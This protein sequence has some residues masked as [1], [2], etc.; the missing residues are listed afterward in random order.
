MKKQKQT[1]EELSIAADSQPDLLCVVYATGKNNGFIGKQLA[2]PIS[3]S[4]V[5]AILFIAI[6]GGKNEFEDQKD[7]ADLVSK[8]RC[9]IGSLHDAAFLAEFKESKAKW[10]YVADEYT[11][12]NFNQVLSSFQQNKKNF[13][14]SGVCIGEFNKTSGKL[15]NP[16]SLRLKRLGFNFLG[17]LLL[18][19]P[20]KDFTHQYLFFDKN[21]VE[22]YFSKNYKNSLSL[23]CK[24]VYENEPIQTYTLTSKDNVQIFSKLGNVIETAFTSRF[25]WFIR[26][27]FQQQRQAK[28]GGNHPYFRLTFLLVVLLA[29]ILLPTLSFDYGITWDA[30]RHNIYG[31][32]ML[33][34]FES[35]GEDKTALSETSSMNEFRYYGEHF[36]VISAWFN[37]NIQAWG[38]FETR[39]FLNALYSFLA[40]L[41]AA[42]ATKEVGSWRSGLFA[43]VFILFS[44]VFFGHGMNNPTDIPFAAGCMMALYYLIKVLKHLPSPKFTYLL[45][46]GAGI[47]MAIG[48]RIGGVVFYAYTGLF[49]GISWL[50]ILKKNGFAKAST[51]FLAYFTSGVT[52]VVIAHLVGISL[53]P[54]G[55]E[56][57]LTNW[58]VALKKSTSA[59]FFTFN[60]ELFEGKRMYMANVPWYYLPKFIIINSPLYIIIGFV[61]LLGSAFVWKRRFNANAIFILMVLFVLLFPIVYAEAQGM[62]Y[63]NGWRH[64]LF[65][66]PPLIILTALGWESLFMISK[67]KIVQVSVTIVLLG[68]IAL[69]ATWMV[70]NHPNEVVYYNE[71]IGGTKGAYGNYELDYYSNSCREAAEWIAHKHPKGKLLVAINNEPLTA[72]YY[73]HKINPDI[74]FQ[75][76]REYEEGKPFW[77]YAIYTSRTYSK[78]ELLNGG[79]PFK[80]TVYEVKADGVPLCVV[81]K[82]NKFDMPLGYKALEQGRLDSAIYYFTSACNDNPMDEEAFRM[83]GMALY[84]A[85][86]VDEA[87]EATNQSIKIF[88]ENYAAYSNLGLFYANGKK[89][90]EKALALLNQSLSYKINYTDAYYYA[91]SIEL[92]RGNNNEAITYLENAISRG[93]N[94]VP[95]MY[96]NL[97]LAYYNVGG[98]GKAEE[99]LT[100]CVTLDAKNAMAYRLLVEV[101]TKQGKKQEA[102]YCMQKYQE[103]GGK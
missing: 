30:K 8:G 21:I 60:H 46:C 69:P 86:R 59:E 10:A 7:I 37:K 40:M 94:G 88:P 81:V 100:Y 2:L 57:P 90:V 13:A 41:F 78:N 76:V 23:L 1:I 99:N 62:Y 12:T 93:G 82:R 92:N 5:N 96:Y 4:K 31:Y 35:D 103:L 83:K 38:E 33:K 67:N 53:W 22:N 27:A 64:Y 75:W 18:P 72:A 77:D 51:T 24:A 14:S 68:F 52:I 91:A 49:M 43:F 102:Q 47:G 9:K 84:S 63:Y 11:T 80:G 19:L 66:Y 74:Q 20:L 87:I 89:D 61:L 17:Q 101:F 36:N 6:E 56:E 98:Y 73:A 71:L 3:K 45:W 48:S 42:L 54:F 32:D 39:H 15:N 95:Q 79:Y 44:P 65:T 29:L 16:F 55:Q 50:A 34:Y 58:Y 26:E 25:N 97:G 85:Q 28:A 70:K